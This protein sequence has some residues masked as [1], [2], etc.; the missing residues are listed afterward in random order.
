MQAAQTAKHL[1]IRLNEALDRPRIFIAAAALILVL[2]AACGIL[3]GYISPDSWYYIMLAQHLRTGL[4]CTMHG[5]YAATYPCGYPTAIALTAPHLTLAGLMISSKVTNLLLLGAS[6]TFVWKGSD[7]PLMAAAAILNPIVLLIGLYT[8]SENLLLFCATGVFFAVSRIA[9]EGRWPD[10]VLLGV[11]LVIGCFARYFFGPF[12]L[13]LFGG[14]WIAYGRTT[15]LKALPA[16]C[17]AGA[18]FL[19]Y[20]TVNQLL[21]GFGTGMPRVPAPETL[22]LTISN[23]I[24]ASAAILAMLALSVVLLVVFAWPLARPSRQATT[25]PASLF[26]ILAGS[27]FLV[28]AFVLRARTLFDPFGVRTIGYGIVLLVAGLV[29]QYVHWRSENRYP[30]IAV[31]VSGLVSLT[32]ADGTAIPDMVGGMTRGDY[33]FPA[34]ELKGLTYKGPPADVIVYFQLPD[35][36]IQTGTI[37]TIEDLYYGPKITLLSPRAGPDNTP[38]TVGDFIRQF[39]GEENK[40]CYV[41]FTPFASLDDFHG[42]LDSTTQTDTSFSLIPGLSQTK[43]KPNLDPGVRAYLTAIFQPGQMV[44]CARILALPQTQALLHHR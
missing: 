22:F 2:T 35:P 16:F 4:G 13:I 6:F 40:R 41:D 5:V 34:S 42:Y 11:I 7:N 1:W 15:A 28:L 37:D 25:D 24:Q 43:T 14:T 27:G 36:N 38:Q 18:V 39:E 44:P 3:F 20:H 21:T 31:L 26:L 19:G 8:W 30:V 10:Q 29:G 32:F 9:R 23:F 12:A 17:V 33:A